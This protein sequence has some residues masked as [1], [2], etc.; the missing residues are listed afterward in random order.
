MD[1]A[2]ARSSGHPG[3]WQKRPLRHL[4]EETDTF[5]TCVELVTSRGVITERSGR[6]VLE[7]ARKLTEHPR[8][9]ALSITDNPGGNAMLSADTLGTDLISRG[10]EVVI[11]LS[12]KDWNRN[13]LQSRGWQLASE[14]FNNVLALSGDYPNEGYRGQ[15]TPVFDTDSVGLLRMF[16]DMN[17]GMTVSAGKKDEVLKR[18]DFYLGAVV[19]NH[20]RH[21]REVMPQYFKLAKKVKNGAAFIIN[22]IG[23]DARKQDELLKY[24]TMHGIDVPVLGNVYVLSRAA[25]RYFNSGNIPGVTVTDD[26]LR[27]V[28]KQAKSRDKGKAFFLDF[29]AKQCA[30]AK[31]L[32]YRGVYIGGHLRYKDYEKV[33]QMIDEFGADDWR[34]FAREICFGYADEFYFFEP[35]GETGLSSN[36]VNRSYLFSKR[37]S[38]LQ[39][40]KRE[41]PLNY[42]INRSLH[43]TAFEEG[44]LGFKAGQKIFRAVDNSRVRKA[45]HGA[46]HAIKSVMFDCRDCGD[47][48]LPEIAFLCPESQCVKNQRNGPCGGTRQG[49]CE[50]GEKD[51]IWGRAYDRLKA[52]GEEERMLDGPAIFKNGALKGTSAWANTF[53]GRDHHARKK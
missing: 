21:E 3:A 49:K 25:A 48:S 6:R 33:L 39:T 46:E 16:S 14:G 40:A 10:Q 34:E 9:H 8:V 31:G 15:A 45:A 22:Q 36:E 18:T 2:Y 52:Y 51:C 7:L 30:I 29:A 20:K 12:C 53:L 43:G 28:E 24:M 32:G 44:T 23:Y 13:A 11:H 50:V 35:A 1:T 27:L 47:C 17:A 5:V 4:I 37:T 41:L 42:K 26:L 19:N 38:A